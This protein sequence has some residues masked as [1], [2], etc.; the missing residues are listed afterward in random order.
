MTIVSVPLKKAVEKS[1]FSGQWR[2]F[3]LRF[4]F[5]SWMKCLDRSVSLVKLPDHCAGLV[6]PEDHSAGLLKLPVHYIATQL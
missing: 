2:Y 1:K 5:P 4:P 6:K 3:F